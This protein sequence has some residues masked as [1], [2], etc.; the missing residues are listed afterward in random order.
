MNH[1]DV[2][3]L[4]Q[5]QDV[6]SGVGST[7]ADVVEPAVVAQG[8]HAGGVDA[9]TADPV[10]AVGGAVAGAGF[11]AGEVGGGGGGLPGQGPVGPTDVVVVDEAVE[12]GLQLS[13][14]SRLGSLRAQPLLGGLLEAFDLAAGGGGVR[15]EFFW[16]TPRR[17]SSA[18]RALRPPLPPDRRMVNTMPLS[19][20][21]EAGAPCA[22]TAA[23]N[24]VSTRAPVTR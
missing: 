4:D 7:D 1:A 5:E 20:R 9:V 16:R 22:A 11:G 14:G 19:V 17:R 13:H 6:G 10:V 8:D 21:V 18:F 12:Q 3:V 24:A 2:Q 23:R 15:A